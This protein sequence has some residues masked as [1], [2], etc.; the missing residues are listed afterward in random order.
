M[1]KETMVELSRA[2]DE[3][4]GRYDRIAKAWTGN[5]P[6]AFMSKKSREALDDR[7]RRLSVNYPRLVVNSRVVRLTVYCFV[8]RETGESAPNVWRTWDRAGLLCKSEKIH[9]D[10]YLYAAAYATVCATMNGRPA[11]TIGTPL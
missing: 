4:R 10:S 5:S 11:V 8:P 1:S 2:I 9:S 7:L 3:R 6:A